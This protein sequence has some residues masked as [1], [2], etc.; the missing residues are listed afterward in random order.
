MAERK[1]FVGTR[2]EPEMVKIVDKMAHERNID[3]TAAMKVLVYTGWKEL[4]LEKAIDLYRK[5]TISLDK[6]AEIA[7]ITIGEMI[8]IA[9]LHGIKS[10]ETLEEYR[11]G[12]RLL[13]N[14]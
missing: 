8:Q 13:L 3:R 11:E 6:A 2:M 4:Q 5:G 12:I 1:T 14:K 7:S 10:E 9:T